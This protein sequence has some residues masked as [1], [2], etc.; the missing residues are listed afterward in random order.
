M[1]VKESLN[2]YFFLFC[3]VYIILYIIKNIK[4]RTNK[5]IYQLILVGSY[6][7][8]NC[9]RK[10]ECLKL[11]GVQTRNRLVSRGFFL[12]YNMDPRL[13]FVHRI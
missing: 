4:L 9:F 7:D 6:C 3:G 2:M 10:Y 12:L 13:I 8:E 1:K 11:L 5:L